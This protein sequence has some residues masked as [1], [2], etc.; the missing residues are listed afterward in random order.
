M[1]KKKIVFIN[2]QFRQSD[3]TARALMELCNHLDLDKFDITIVAVYTC[4]QQ[5]A[6]QLNSRIHLKKIFGFD[7]RG[8]NRLVRLIPPSLLYKKY[9]GD[10]Y[11]IEIAFQCDIP[12]KIVGNSRHPGKVQVCWMHGYENYP[13]QYRNVDKVVCVSH[14]NAKRCKVELE[15]EQDVRC[16]YNLLND[17]EILRRGE[18]YAE[19]PQGDG[20]L[21][22]SVGRLSPEK[23]F[24]RLVEV[25]SQLRSE[26]FAFRMMIVGGG[27]EMIKLRRKIYDLHMENCVFLMGEQKNPHRFTSKAD[28]FICSSF[29][30]GYSTAC[31]EAAILGVPIL[32]TNVPGAEEIISDC[33]CGM[34][35]ELDDESLKEGISTILLKPQCLQEWKEILNQNR[36][37]FGMKY[38]KKAAS[39][40]FDEL[41]AISEKRK[42]PQRSS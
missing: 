20:P 17:E 35:T 11:D 4:E 39:D 15:Y 36:H 7:F 22:V 16:C 9:I 13:E 38:R 10:A 32:S 14:C 31:A 8:M 12:T 24:A 6:R 19:C 30:E 25:L 5:F 33:E 29:S 40:L 2:N 37:R 3:G 41:F 27:C 1:A 23:G 34:V 21:F 26:G 42:S 28:L 18:E